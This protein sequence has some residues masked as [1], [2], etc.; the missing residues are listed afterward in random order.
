MGVFFQSVCISVIAII[1]TGCATPQT[2]SYRKFYSYLNEPLPYRQTTW[3]SDY[4]LVIFVDARHLD[5]TNNAS[6][7]RTVAKHPSDCS[8]TGDVGHAWIYLQGVL[9]GEIVYIEGGHSGE[10]GV[11]QAKYFDGIMNYIDFGYANPTAEQM[12]APRY[13]P[14]PAKYLWDVQNDGYFEWGSGGHKATFAAKIDITQQQFEK[15]LEFIYTYDYKH[16]S[17]VGNQCSSFASHIGALA[18]IYLDCE[19][20]IDIE[21]VMLF[22]GE[23]IRFWSDPS[24]AKLTTSTPDVLER[25]LIKAVHS[26]SM[27]RVD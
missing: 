18:G 27:Q 14:N 8:K 25:S 7:F 5:Y 22:R 11:I 21:S 23:K 17:L 1:V 9:D 13:E 10:R 19:T 6:F 15:I 24:Y 26:G 4:F 2:P 20:T 16:Y 12:D 3:S